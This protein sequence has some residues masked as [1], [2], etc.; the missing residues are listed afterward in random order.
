MKNGVTFVCNKVWVKLQFC[1]EIFCPREVSKDTCGKLLV[2]EETKEIYPT[3][4][5]LALHFGRVC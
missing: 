4:L 3:T 5:R 2:S 1:V